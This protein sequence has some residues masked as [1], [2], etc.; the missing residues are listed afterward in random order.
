MTLA[1]LFLLTLVSLNRDRMSRLRQ[2][3][4]YQLFNIAYANML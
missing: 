3:R 4:I 2:V 1:G